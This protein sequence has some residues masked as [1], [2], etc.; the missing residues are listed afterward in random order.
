MYILIPFIGTKRIK[1]I[2]KK[3][4]KHHIIDNM[5]SV[6]NYEEA[7]IDWECARFTK[8]DKPETAREITDSEKFK[9]T[10]HYPFLI[11]ELEKF[12]L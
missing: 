2:H 3:I 5:Y 12:G 4:N 11:K 10:I 1:M 7:I 8:S 6:N 9:N